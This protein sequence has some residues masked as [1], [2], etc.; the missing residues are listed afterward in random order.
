MA[1]PNNQTSAR[2]WWLIIPTFVVFWFAYLTFFGPRRHPD[3]E[4]SGS[5]QPADYTWTVVDLDDRP[6]SFSKFQGR[7]VFLNIWATWCG[8]CVAELPSI[9]RL[10]ND[11]HLRKLPIDFVCASTDDSSQTV[12]QF[13]K[14]RDW[15]MTFL[16]AEKIPPIFYSDGIPATFLIAA[17]GRIAAV[18]IGSVEWDEPKVVAFLEKLASESGKPRQQAKP[19]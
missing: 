17:D 14:G 11:P 6:V 2:I 3:L 16:R 19:G 18:Q 15:P 13:L 10:A 1:E 7:T 4:H 9:A 12:K 5:D 8:P